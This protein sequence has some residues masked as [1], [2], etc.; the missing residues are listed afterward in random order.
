MTSVEKEI[1]LKRLR[2]ENKLESD[3][4]FNHVV[5]A[6]SIARMGQ[7]RIA[8]PVQLVPVRLEL[9]AE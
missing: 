2:K 3:R 4:I 5:I 7:E 6:D 8:L 1:V 9:H